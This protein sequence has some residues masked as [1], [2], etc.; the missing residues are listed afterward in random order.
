[1]GNQMRISN[2]QAKSPLGQGLK[3]LFALPLAAAGSWIL[4]SHLVI[5]HSALLPEA[6]PGERKIFHSPAAG[7]ISYYTQP[8]AGGRP[9][10]LIHSI[11]AAASAYE[12]RPLY[13]AFQGKRPVTALDLP[14]FGYS[15][16][17]K[18]VYSPGLYTHVIL[19]FL[20]AVVGEP[21]DVV[22]LSLGCEFAAHAALLQPE[23]FS[24]LV[25]ISPS[26]FS[27]GKG[28]RGSQQASR[29]GLGE[30]LHAAFAVPLWARPFYDLLTTRA[31]I[32]YFLRQSFIGPVP[33]DL[34]EYDYAAAHQPGAEH[35]PLYF[36]SGR[37]FTPEICQA[38]Y[39]NL[40]IPALVLYDRDSFVSFDMLPAAL[41]TNPYLRAVR[42]VPTLGLPH[43]EQTEKTVE[44]LERFWE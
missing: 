17:T 33:P 7:K 23:L 44:V 22:A 19:E 42:L 10:V 24:S 41:E 30:I 26:G 1:M 29:S 40:Q 21:A 16:R 9:T 5:N 4:Y 6:V 32:E 3:G 8:G 14:G 2:N 36:I 34:V 39:E 25:M 27:Q 31:S 18:R 37:L 20:S 15:D 13:T 11:N 43:F 35:A 28:D 12:M 38:V